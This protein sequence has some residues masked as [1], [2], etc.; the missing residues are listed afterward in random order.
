[1]RK[2]LKSKRGLNCEPTDYQSGIITITVKSK[3][4]ERELEKRFEL[5]WL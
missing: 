4:C 1:M 2:T 3:L 5:D